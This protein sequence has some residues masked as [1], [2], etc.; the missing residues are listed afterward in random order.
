MFGLSATNTYWL[1][2]SPTDMRKSFDGLSGIVTNHLCRNPLSG[3]VFLFINKRRDKLKLL[4]WQ[5]DG[6]VLYYK[7]LE[8]GTFEQL[9]VAG[10]AGSRPL[11]WSELAMLIEGITIENTKKRKRYLSPLKCG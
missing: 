1:Y 5:P 11:R 2:E 4:Q 10:G 6:F 7:R 9:S 3:E 8:S